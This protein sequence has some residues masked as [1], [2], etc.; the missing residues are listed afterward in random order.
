MPLL[1][2]RTA[3]WELRR[4]GMGSR[5]GKRVRILRENGKMKM[6]GK[7]RMSE[8]GRGSSGISVG[9]EVWSER[10]SRIIRSMRG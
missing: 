5:K 9:G 6:N 4:I 2:Q 3:C 10:Y 8:I 7:V 1:K